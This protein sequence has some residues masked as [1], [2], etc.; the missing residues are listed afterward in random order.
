MLLAFLSALLL[1]I[2]AGLL[3]NKRNFTA[4]AL[5]LFIDWLAG[6]AWY[7][8][9]DDQ[10]PWMILIVVDWLAALSVL[11]F[12]ESRWQYWI[13]AIFIV[14]IICH[15]GFGLSPPNNRWIEY[16]YWWMLTYSGIAQLVVMGG[17]LTHEIVLRI[18]RYYCG[19]S[20]IRVDAEIIEP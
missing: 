4:T 16:N 12:R 5:I 17:W 2:T 10:Y 18:A 15:V 14:Q 8:V 6:N 20:S 11:A 1:L 13:V 9:T 19:A 7:W 3:L